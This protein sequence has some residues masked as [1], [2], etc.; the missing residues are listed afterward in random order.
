LLVGRRVGREFDSLDGGCLPNVGAEKL[1]SEVGEKLA[2]DG[3]REVF[4]PAD[5]VVVPLLLPHVFLIARV[6]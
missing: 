6:I 4:V 3:W 2:H 5:G 1:V